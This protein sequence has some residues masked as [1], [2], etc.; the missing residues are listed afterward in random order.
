MYCTKYFVGM[1]IRT[2][3]NVKRLVTLNISNHDLMMTSPKAKSAQIFKCARD[4]VA[5]YVSMRKSE[6]M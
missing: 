5:R 1:D 6:K 4:H 3:K 2:L